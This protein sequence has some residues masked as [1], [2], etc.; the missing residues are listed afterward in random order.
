MRTMA[1]TVY[2]PDLSQTLLA[3]ARSLDGAALRLYLAMLADRSELGTVARSF[4]A[5]A[6]ALGLSWRSI[7]R[8]A[9][10]LVKSGVLLKVREL[11]RANEYAVLDAAA[12]FG[13]VV[14]DPN[15]PPDGSSGTFDK[16]PAAG[17]SVLHNLSYAAGVICHNGGRDDTGGIPNGGGVYQNA[18]AGAR[19][20]KSL[21]PNTKDKITPPSLS[22]DG[23]GR[24]LSL[25]HI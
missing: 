13:P 20:A 3:A 1:P 23:P 17:R 22:C 2:T 12:V 15:T 8:A 25:I 14:L 6:D 7:A 5:Y 18:G 4:G 10:E 19:R 9:D 16:R 21:S 11:R 24:D